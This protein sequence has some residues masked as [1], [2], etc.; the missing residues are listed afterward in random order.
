MLASGERTTHGRR[1]GDMS[2]NR[3]V[4]QGGASRRRSGGPG[5]PMRNGS[6]G[7]EGTL[8]R[9]R[10]DWSEAGPWPRMRDTGLTGS[11]GLY[12]RDPRGQSADRWRPGGGSRAPAHPSDPTP[13]RPDL[14]IPRGLRS[15]S[16]RRPGEGIT[17]AI[18]S[19][20][21]PP[22]GIEARASAHGVRVRAVLRPALSAKSG[23]QHRRSRPTGDRPP[24][25]PDRLGDR[26]SGPEALA[27]NPEPEDHR[28]RISRSV[29]MP[30]VSMVVWISATY[31][32]PS[33]T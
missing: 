31:R 29:G 30:S 16:V 9:A 2:K 15:D 3:L 26:A 20:S 32:R 14:G 28:W 7:S 11:G 13:E 12:R 21:G 8:S 5:L 6:V 10:A 25:I 24:I 33:W 4:G 23:V 17:S 27:P 18:R 22:A 19:R 1:S